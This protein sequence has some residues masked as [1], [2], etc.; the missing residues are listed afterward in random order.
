MNYELQAELRRIIDELPS[1]NSCLDYKAFPYENSKFS[2]FIKDLC[3]FLNSEDGYG[4]N[5]FIIIGIDDNKN[6][7][8]LSTVP[9]QDDRQYQQAADN[10]F[11]RPQI[12]TGTFKH[13]K[14]GVEYE[15]GYIY[16]N[17]EN[18]DRVYEINKDYF[19]KKDNNSYFLNAALSHIAVGSTAWIR[20]GSCKRLLDEY[21]RRKIYELERSRKKMEITEEIEYVNINNISNNKIIKTALFFGQWNEN[22]KNDKKMIEQYTGFS[23]NEFVEKF[24][25]VAK[26]EVDF[27]FKKNCWR[28][29][30]REK[31]LR[32]YSLE[33]YKEDF[34]EMKKVVVEILKEKKPKLELDSD[35]RIMANVYNKIT[36]YSDE[37]REGVAEFIT[38]TKSINSSFENCKN[39]VSNFVVLSIR[40]ILEKSSWNIW[41]SL[42]Q[43]LPYLAEAAPS[44][45]LNQLE[46]YIVGSN[47]ERIFCECEIGITT[48]NYTTPIYWSL[49]LIAWDT[50]YCVR[51]CMILSKMARYDFNAIDHIANII[52]PWHPNT[53]A[54]VSYR[55]TIVDNILKE[56]ISIGW[57]LLK[58]LMPGEITYSFPTNK[59]KYI[60]VPEDDRE[61]TNIEY[62]EQ[63]DMYISLMIKYCKASDDRILDLVDL[64]DNVSKN[65][66]EKICSYL[67][68][69]KITKKSDSSK[70]K[71]WNKLEKLKHW[72]KKHSKMND[73]IKKEMLG[74]IEEVIVEI[75][76]QNNLYLISNLYKKD[77]WEFIDDYENYEESSKALEKLQFEAINKLYEEQGLEKIIELN[78]IVEDSFLLGMNVARINSLKKEEVQIIFNNLNASGKVLE[79]SKGFVYKKYN[80]RKE[81]YDEELVNNL[82]LSGKIEFLLMLPYNIMTFKYVREKLNKQE[83]KYWKKV[84]IRF[85][86][87]EEDLH[88]CI[89]KLIE[90]KRYDRV[91][92][93]YRLAQHRKCKF[94]YNN[95]IILECLENINN[96]FNQYD[97]CEA[98]RDL[99]KNN[100]DANRMFY[101]EWKYLPL[102]NHGDN[103]PIT[104]EKTLAS[105]PEKYS[106]ILELAF[107]EH[108]KKSE[109]RNINPD[110]ATN[111]YRLLHQ[112][113]YVPGT[114]DD[115]Y[116]DSHKLNKW[117]EDMKIICK[118][119]DRLEVGLSYFGHVLFYAGKDKTN[120]W[121]DRT[122]A[123][124][125]NE[126]E[127]VRDGYKNQAFNAVGVVNCDEEGSEY[128][129][130]RNLYK[131]KAE[132][133]ELEGYYNF[134]TALREIAENFEFHAEHMKE[135]YNDI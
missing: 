67:K 105:S 113:K 73:L 96:N 34:E 22:N 88:Y 23:Y 108:S 95:E 100:A 91:L 5:K 2:E 90:V 124:I 109:K 129:K 58:K 111:A 17:K 19:Y 117:F 82:A 120:F 99:Q 40:E 44:E 47:S 7:L 37:M 75:K 52:L 57:N 123:K 11:P 61:T 94:Q 25:A 112:W 134:A 114:K 79:F 49:E 38:I 128:I 76:P 62:Y 33:Y 42:D 107:K 45:F 18:T 55:K 77:N 59:P 89:L 32:H 65:N 80:I 68:T 93:I 56:D 29:N 70:Y 64:L 131:E 10:I 104:M 84:D 71:I 66:F 53:N 103:R 3:A 41:A 1:E 43:L 85:I 72:I 110:V 74:K 86:E 48:Y 20:R 51:A 81:K 12:E 127:L 132:K 15:F 26:K 13:K 106:E 92:W 31:Y 14:N 102:L 135:T 28:I 115:D 69:N 6:I 87:D 8:G 83:Y 27:V 121:I 125:L 118:K 21:T 101:I 50:E 35:K 46:E 63:I 78:K 116:I 122:V 9:M 97:I 130:L 30:N 36:K 4:K 98:I 39:S 24:R 133:T 119:K 126:E 16:I 60:N 54:P